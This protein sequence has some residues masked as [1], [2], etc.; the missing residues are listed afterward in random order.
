MTLHK[1]KGLEFNIVFHL[2]LY[3]WILPNEYG[4]A[5]SQTQDLNLHYFD[6]KRIEIAVLALHLVNTVFPALLPHSA[7]KQESGQMLAR[8]GFGLYGPRVVL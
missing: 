5:D 2:D 1:S 7:H 4:D 8:S 6:T 3:K